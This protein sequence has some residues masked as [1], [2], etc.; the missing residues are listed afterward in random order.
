[1][2]ISVIIPVKNRAHLIGETL[3]SIFNQT[4]KPYEVIVVDDESD[5]DLTA[6]L[7]K[8]GPKIKLLRN[9]GH[10]PGAGRNTGLKAATGDAIQFFDSDDLMSENKFEVQAELL[11]KEKADFVYGPY[12]RAILNNN[13]WERTDAIMQYKPLPG[14]SLKNLVLEG[15]CL[16]QTV[17]FRTDF[18]KRVGFWN[19]DLPAYEDFEYGFRIAKYSTKQV[20]ETQSFVLYREHADQL[21]Q[22][23]KGLEKKINNQLH[24]YALIKG[25]IDFTPQ[26][27]SYL[28]FLGTIASAKKFSNKAKIL[29]QKFPLTPFDHLSALYHRVITKVSLLRTGNGWRRIYGA[30]ES[31]ELFQKYLRQINTNTNYPNHN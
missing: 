26:L 12:A 2:K 23:Q 9:S 30:V 8:F 14:R 21:T 11:N 25:G 4:L 18:L 22:F 16:T 31:E 24:A 6:V 17:L 20:H 5:D 1:M 28:V 19:E 29:P 7:Q 27:H 10:G 13:K 15:W 3:N